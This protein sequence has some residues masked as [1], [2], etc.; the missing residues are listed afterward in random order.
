MTSEAGRSR[1]FPVLAGVLFLLAV[2]SAILG[3]I[4]M[5]DSSSGPSFEMGKWLL[6]LAT[7][8]T[9]AGFLTALLRQVEV[10]RAKREAWTVMLQDLVVG[11]DDIEAA[12]LRLI[13]N[14]DAGTYADM[15]EK[16]RETRARLR[17]VMA[18][19]EATDHSSELRRHVQRMRHY[20]KP[21]LAE[22][23]INYLHVER[24]SQL[25]RKLL[26]AS[27]E[28]LA[29]HPQPTLPGHLLGPAGVGVL[30][31]DAQQFPSLAA[32]LQDFDTSDSKFREGSELD[33]AYESV[34]FILRKNAGIGR[35]R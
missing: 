18:L 1:A 31:R 16:C 9:G 4:I 19:P 3:F 20:L 30:L 24:Q 7:V 21:L 26:D 25:D 28:R 15:V 12:C 13:S 8:F 23:E 2:G 11:Q 10:T 27:L 35:R 33:S 6:Q 22:Y 32:C 29:S 5:R 17:R 14:A 34:K